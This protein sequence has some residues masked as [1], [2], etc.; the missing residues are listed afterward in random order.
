MTA[1]R[2]RRWLLVALLLLAAAACFLT[3]ALYL[4]GGTLDDVRDFAALNQFV[5]GFRRVQTD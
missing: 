5:H 1:R 4:S 2:K 3:A